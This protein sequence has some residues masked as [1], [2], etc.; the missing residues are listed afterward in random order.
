MIVTKVFALAVRLDAKI[1]NF[2]CTAW[3]WLWKEWYAG[4]VI[5]AIGP[6]W[7]K[8][9]KLN[10]TIAAVRTLPV[11]RPGAL[12]GWTD[13]EKDFE[14]LNDSAQLIGMVYCCGY[15]FL[16]YFQFW[17]LTSKNGAQRRVAMVTTES[18]RWQ[19]S[20][21]AQVHYPCYIKCLLSVQ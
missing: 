20:R 5:R 16:Y 6:W 11:L 2:I 14:K 15:Y 17:Q 1:K 12:S 4:P 3:V 19:G 8:P 7:R 13:F 9:R 10:Q 18:V 21:D